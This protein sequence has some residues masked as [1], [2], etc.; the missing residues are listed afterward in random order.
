MCVLGGGG[1]GGWGGVGV[2][3]LSVMSNLSHG[4]LCTC[5]HVKQSLFSRPV[6]RNEGR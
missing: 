5:Q 4:S 1:G 2:T 6:S 3:T